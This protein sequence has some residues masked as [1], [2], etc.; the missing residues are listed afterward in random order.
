[1]SLLRS[2]I[3]FHQFLKRVGDIAEEAWDADGVYVM[4][5][6]QMW[7]KGLQLMGWTRG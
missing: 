7:G 5:E 1:M 6:D 4:L 2:L 3:S